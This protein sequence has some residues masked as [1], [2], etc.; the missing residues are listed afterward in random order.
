MK[1]TTKKFLDLLFN[2]GETICVTSGNYGAH[3]I[4]QSEIGPVINLK[5]PNKQFTISE[6]DIQ[7]VG[8]NPIKGFKTD[9]NVTA[10]RNFM[11]E[12]DDGTIAQQIKYIK[13]SGI[14]YSA[15]VFSGNKSMHYVIAL[16][17]GYSESIWRFVNQWILNI[18][19]AA[20]QQNKSPSRGVRFPGNKRKN[21]AK[22]MQV[23]KELHGRITQSDLNNWLAKFPDKKPRIEAPPVENY[24]TFIS[25]GEL[26][27]FIV[28]MLKNLQQGV[29]PERNKSWFRASSYMAKRG[30]SVDMA[31]NIC[32]KYFIEED[33]F[34]ENELINCIKS[35]YR[36]R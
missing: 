1:E 31:T 2:E 13:D 12:L 14:P 30:M 28:A 20:D 18:L 11:L 15:C 34:K 8:I 36:Y 22:K 26:P 5:T 19:K 9:N 16:T 33:D 27:A 25:E 6:D 10:Y 17:Q 4:E 29:Q 23:L 21:G 24:G 35:A 32:R 7:L 3:S